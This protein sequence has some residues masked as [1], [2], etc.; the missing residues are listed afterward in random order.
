MLIQLF[1]FVLRVY[2]GT[3]TPPE[4][5]ATYL[6]KSVH[7][8]SNLD[9]VYFLSVLGNRNPEMTSLSRVITRITH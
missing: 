2:A 1:C 6:V 4:R 3:L 9:V 8:I 5:E 7:H